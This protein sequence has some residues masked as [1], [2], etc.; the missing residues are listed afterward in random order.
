MAVPQIVN[1]STF[2][3]HNT[4]NEKF[5]ENWSL[6]T[7]ANSQSLGVKNSFKLNEGFKASDPN[8]TYSTHKSN[9]PD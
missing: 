6:S 7:Q 1:L 4:K 9:K 2:Y 8:S 3:M 5:I